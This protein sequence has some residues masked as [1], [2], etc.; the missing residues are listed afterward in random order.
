M[1]SRCTRG[2]TDIHLVVYNVHDY[3]Q[4]RRYYPA[5][6]RAARCEHGSAVLEHHGRRHRAQRPFACFD[7]IRHPADQ[8]IGVCYAGFGGKI[9]HFVIQQK[10]GTVDTHSGTERQVERIAVGNHVAVPVN[11]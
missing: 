6:A 10:A 5:A 2:D 8:S 9:I 4:Y 11:D 3:L 1:H 7:R